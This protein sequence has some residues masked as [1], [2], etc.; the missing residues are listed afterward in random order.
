MTSHLAKADPEVMDAIRRETERQKHNL[1]LIASENI[2]SEAVLEAQG[3]V[4]TNKYAEGYSGKRYYGGCEFVDVVEDLAI[5]RVK[6]LFGAD[7]ANVQPHSGSQANMAV[8][9]SQLEPG[10][11]ML[12]MN[13]SHGGHLTHGSPVNFSGKFFNVVHYGVRESDHRL[14][15]EQ[16][17]ALARQ[18]KPK[19]IVAGYSA[20][21]REL[22]FARFRAI[23]DEVGALLMTDM[24][25]FAGLVA[26]G[27]HP[28][29]VSHCDFVTSTTHKTLRGPRGGLILCKEKHA[30]SLN[31]SVF[32]GNQGGPLMHVIAAKAVAFKEALAPEFKAY[33]RQ[34]VANAKALAASLVGHGFSLL[35]GGTDNHLMM[36]DLRGS[37]LTGKVAEA[38]LDQ[39]RITVNKNTV[40]FDPRSPMVTSGVRIG[41]PAVT[42]RG[43]RE[44][45]MAVVGDLI[46]RALA[47]VGD[48]AALRAIGDEVAELCRRFPIYPERSTARATP[49]R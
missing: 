26:A 48:A 46:A 28:S 2:V 29:P 30:K 34:I 44:A 49:E 9:F 33:Q 6:E 4:L 40:P 11:T 39:A 13:L 45:D 16:L 38:T 47:R 25:H 10:S 7:H 24:A 18:H 21:P 12:A 36:L 43:M 8:Y 37:E 15:Y 32:P 17:E 22:D 31:S 5:A 3:S 14:D 23:A 20:Y 41:T 19:M 27:V 42:S 1:E 35:T